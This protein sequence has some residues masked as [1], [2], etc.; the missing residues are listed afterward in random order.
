MQM[1]FRTRVISIVIILLLASCAPPPTPANVAI[2]TLA[3]YLTPPPGTARIEGRLFQSPNS[4]IPVSNAALTLFSYEFNIPPAET[5]TDAQG[6]Y[7]FRNVVP[8]MYSLMVNGWSLSAEEFCMTS[9]FLQLEAHEVLEQDLTCFQQDPPFISTESNGFSNIGPPSEPHFGDIHFT[10]PLDRSSYNRFNPR[11]IFP[12]GLHQI[13][14][15][16]D[17]YLADAKEV[18]MIW[19]KDT[20]S[21]L[22]ETAVVEPGYKHCQSTFSDPEG[23]A[24]GVYELEVYLS[25]ELVKE[26]QFQVRW[27]PTIWQ[28]T[29]AQGLDVKDR[30]ILATNLFPI[31]TTLIYAIFAVENFTKGQAIPYDLYYND[32]VFL[33][34]SESWE[35][36]DSAGTFYMTVKSEKGFPPGRYVLRLYGSDWLEQIAN[37][38]IE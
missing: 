7:S 25:G 28:V 37:F 26:G 19:Y 5:S 15:D 11:T 30:P 31:G 35:Q 18:Q 4:R 17:C 3:A 12:V 23:L 29:F 9:S 8:G 34:G 32:Q 27:R 22:E 21:I 1:K 2:Q 6:R 24:E 38:A 13:I 33:S 36:P 10:S 16:F 14:G 20:I